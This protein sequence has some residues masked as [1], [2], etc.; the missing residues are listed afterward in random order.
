[1]TFGLVI[2]MASESQKKKKTSLFYLYH[3]NRPGTDCM[4]KAVAR[5]PQVIDLKAS[6]IINVESG[7]HRV[8]ES[9]W[10]NS[11]RSDLVL[12]PDEQRSL[13]VEFQKTV[14]K[15][16]IK[17]AISYCLQ[18]NSRYDVDPVVLTFCIDTGATSTE[19]KRENIIRLPRCATI[20]CDFW[21]AE[22]LILGK[23]T[24]HQRRR[25]TESIDRARNV[26]SISGKRD[27]LITKM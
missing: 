15:K 14:D 23:K 22:C 6:S 17:R 11:T 7:I 12:I 21:A 1:M 27:H 10:A 18:A 9:E 20:S 16:I 4:C 24:A 3:A 5:N 2:F 25:I 8:D 19:Q 13:I 26:F